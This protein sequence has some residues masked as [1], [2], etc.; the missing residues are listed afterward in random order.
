MRVNIGQVLTKKKRI[1]HR[2]CIVSY[3]FTFSISAPQ[4]Q[5]RLKWQ[6]GMQ[7]QDLGVLAYSYQQSVCFEGEWQ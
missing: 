2:H 6:K 1:V 3:L 5:L 7:I 4:S